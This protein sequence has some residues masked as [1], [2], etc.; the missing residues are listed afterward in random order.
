VLG[1][2]DSYFSF[3]A[4]FL[5]SSPWHFAISGRF[6]NPS[7]GGWTLFSH[8]GTRSGFDKVRRAC[9]LP[10]GQ[11]T[12]VFLL[13]DYLLPGTPCFHSLPRPSF[14]ILRLS[15]FALHGYLRCDIFAFVCSLWRLLVDVPFCCYMRPLRRRIRWL[16]PLI[17]ILSLALFSLPLPRGP[18]D[19]G[20]PKKHLLLSRRRCL[21]L[22]F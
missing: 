8:L 7:S 4:V 10:T 9:P 16:L 20:Q 22:N 17:Q 19:E 3:P 21:L 2:P 5:G 1:I 13:H 14:H 6:C 12:L 11:S 15:N 18:N